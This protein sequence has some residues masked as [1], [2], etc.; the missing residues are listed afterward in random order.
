MAVITYWSTIMQSQPIQLGHAALQHAELLSHERPLG[1]G[2]A[3][4]RRNVLY[5]LIREAADDVRRKNKG[6]VLK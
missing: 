2:F 1:N 5:L 4:F 3:A 6:E